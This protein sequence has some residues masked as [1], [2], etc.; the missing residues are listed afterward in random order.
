[1]RF[2]ELRMS[3]AIR[4]PGCSKPIVEYLPKFFVSFKFDDVPF[5]DHD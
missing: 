1:M 4:R 5:L 2:T 3:M